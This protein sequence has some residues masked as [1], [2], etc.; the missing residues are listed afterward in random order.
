MVLYDR[1]SGRSAR[2][3]QQ[4]QIKIFTAPRRGLIRNDSYALPVGEGAEVLDNFFPTPQG[5]SLRGGL[6]RHA[7]LGAEVTHYAVYNSGATDRLFGTTATSIFDVTTPADPN[8]PPT[9]DVTGQTSGDYSSEQFTTTGG[10][11]LIL[12]N[13]ADDM[14]QYNGTTW[15]T[16]NAGSTPNITGVDTADLSAVWKFKNRLFFI[17]EGTLSAWYL[18]VNS[19][20]GAAAEFPL[21][22]IFRQGGTL[23]FG[24]TWSLDAGDG[25]DDVCVFVTTE[26]EMAIY[27]GTDPSD[28]NSFS[29]VGVYQIGRPLGK[30][31]WF[32]A[33]GDIGIA[34]DEGV[35][36]VS[37]AVRQDRAAVLA[38]AI[39]FPIEDLWRETVSNSRGAGS[40]TMELWH[41]ETMLVVGV[42]T[43]AGE[44][45][46]CLIANARTGA[47]ARYTGWDAQAVAVFQDRLYIGGSAGRVY[48]ANVTGQDDDQIYSGVLIPRFDTF[49][50][51]E[52]KQALSVRLNSLQRTTVDY[53]VF[54]NSDW[55]TQIPS[56]LPANP[57]ESTSVWGTARW[58][59][60]VWGGEEATRRISEWRSVRG[61]G[62]SLAP[63]LQITSGRETRPQVDLISLDLMYMVG[64]VAG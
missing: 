51:A 12:V 34:T 25:L 41:S 47:W 5:A 40:F 49:E 29:L 7:T 32:R 23:L 57:D 50:M 20:A 38:N 63:G 26:G 46:I 10:V 64:E 39:S 17:E 8:V 11:F 19:I 59:Q 22:G 60:F 36:P 56:P 14:Q 6:L 27:Q 62:Y 16:I 2:R 9:A 48:Q 18:P 4:S 35:V 31:A 52:E 15:T 1:R 28:A 24:V 37:S 21:G 61:N 53:Q 3:Q 30:N 55:I 33:G 45:N 43:G 42:P 13:G 54:C 58:G 44:E